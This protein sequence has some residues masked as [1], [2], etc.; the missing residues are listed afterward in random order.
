MYYGAIYYGQY[1]PQVVVSYTLTC[2]P[3]AFVVTGQDAQFT[4]VQPV[5]PPTPVTTTRG[6]GSGTPG[7]KPRHEPTREEFIQRQRETE[8]RERR[9]RESEMAVAIAADDA[10][11]FDIIEQILKEIR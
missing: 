11:M 3:G 2:D 4:V 1:F 9:E 10:E 6:K 5:V 8:V 7:R